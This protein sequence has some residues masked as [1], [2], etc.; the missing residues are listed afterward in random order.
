MSIVGYLVKDGHVV[1]VFPRLCSTFALIFLGLNLL[2][3]SQC[4]GW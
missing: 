3:F 4:L 1:F 2:L